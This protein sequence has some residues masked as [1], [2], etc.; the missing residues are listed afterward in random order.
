MRA[1][2]PE[3]PFLVPGI[4]AQGGD[5]GASLRAGR[6]RNGRGLLINSSRDILHAPEPREAA[7]RL[8]DAIAAGG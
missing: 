2:A 7:L 6:D 4:G 1:A 8:R 3:L 5:L